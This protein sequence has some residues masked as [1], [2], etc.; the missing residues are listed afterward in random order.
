MMVEAA[1]SFQSALSIL[2]I[3]VICLGVTNLL[4]KRETKKLQKEQESKK[5]G[6]ENRKVIAGSGPR[7]FEQ[8]IDEDDETDD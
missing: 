8:K 1:L 4:Q 3:E 7:G 5:E 6:G 2:I